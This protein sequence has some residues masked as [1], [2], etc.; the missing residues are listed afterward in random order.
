MVTP[1]PYQYPHPPV[2]MACNAESGAIIAGEDGCGMLS[3]SNLQPLSKLKPVIDAYRDAQKRAK[4][5]TGV[6]T[7][8]V[9]IYTMVY[10]AESRATFEQDRLWDSM[11]WWYRNLAEFTM[12][13]ELANVSEEEREA[14]YPLLRKR[15]AGDFDIRQFDEEDMVIVGTPDEC[16]EKFLKY[17]EIGVDQMLCYVNFGYLPNEAVLR[18]LELLGTYVI[19]ALKKR[20]AQRMADGLAS[21]IKTTEKKVWAA[22]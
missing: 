13:W 20:G 1:K 8:Q 19:P 17:D 22:Y 4:P 21:S 7:N 10:C 11:W 12:K 9:G 6:H 2:W 14:A 16:V 15:A 3:F 18:S 5:L